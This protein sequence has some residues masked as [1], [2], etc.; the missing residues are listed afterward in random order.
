M[1][2]K[3]RFI[4]KT[5]KRR[6]YKRKRVATYSAQ[7]RPAKL[8]IMRSL[9]TGRNIHSFSRRCATQLITL[10]ANSVGVGAGY[11]FQFNQMINSSEFSVLFDMYKITRVTMEFHLHTNPFIEIGTNP[12]NANSVG[13]APTTFPT[14]YI[15]NDHDDAAAPTLDAMKE[16]S[17]TKRFVLAPN[18]FI[19]WSCKPAILGQ[20]YRTA[21]TT[22][23]SPQW[24]KWID[25]GNLDVPHY[26]TKLFIDYDGFTVPAAAAP[27]GQDITVN[28]ETKI[29]FTC[30]DVR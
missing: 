27:Y 19:K 28:M 20:L 25:M 4:A 8:S 16:C 18:K 14:L 6:S 12:V 10:S 22:G 3:R 5:L 11:Q 15:R 9:T 29:W 1:A 24:N 13:Y 7:R 26:G 23:Y 17:S 2:F 21:V 30:K